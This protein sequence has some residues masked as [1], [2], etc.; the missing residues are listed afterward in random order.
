M[1]GKR[2]KHDD[3]ELNRL[4]YMVDLFFSSGNNVRS[5]IPVPAF[6]LR[7]FPFVKKIVGIRTDMFV[8]IQEFIRVS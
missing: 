2:F 5:N 3:E 7:N 6:V 8:P 4:L 1:A